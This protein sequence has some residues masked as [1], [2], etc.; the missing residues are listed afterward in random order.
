MRDVVHVHVTKD[1]PIR[2]RALPFADRVEIR[3]GKAFPV[4]LI[5]DRLALD[6]LAEAIE[7]GRREL[8][9]ANRPG[10]NRQPEDK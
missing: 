3:F 9:A 4:V 10:E 8:D 2:A 1:L 6:S 5:A 7:T